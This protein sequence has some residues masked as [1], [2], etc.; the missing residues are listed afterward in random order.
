MNTL[1]KT[2]AIYKF[3]GDKFSD[4]SLKDASCQAVLDQRGKCIRGRNGN[5]LVNFNGIKGVVP[6][7]QLRKLDPHGIKFSE[8]VSI[9]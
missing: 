1:K 9:T 6:A 4:S 3:R 7:R 2:A 5:M 8:P